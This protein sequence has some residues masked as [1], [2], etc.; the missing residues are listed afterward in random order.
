[1]YNLAYL[2]YPLHFYNELNIKQQ[3][4]KHRKYKTSSTFKRFSHEI[5]RNDNAYSQLIYSP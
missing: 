1:M 2:R 3:L 5:K 4:F